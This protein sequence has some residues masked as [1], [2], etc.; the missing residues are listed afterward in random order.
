MVYPRRLAFTLQGRGHHLR[1][2]QIDTLKYNMAFGNFY[3]WSDHLSTPQFLL[4]ALDF[5]ERDTIYC[6]ANDCM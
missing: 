4:T 1:D 6:Q 2:C 5:Y 3:D